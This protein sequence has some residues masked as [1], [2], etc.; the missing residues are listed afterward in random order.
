[1][2]YRFKID[3]IPKDE[4]VQQ[5][6]KDKMI[7]KGEVIEV[8]GYSEPAEA[9]VCYYMGGI[10]VN[11]PLQAFLLV[12]EECYEPT[13]IH[14]CVK[15]KH[16]KKCKKIFGRGLINSG[17]YTCARYEENTITE[18]EIKKLLDESL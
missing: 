2:K 11:I 7:R 15:C 17:F 18:E 4:E 12:A 13:P 1:M 6:L 9:V 14:L 8:V 16:Y 10:Q 3:Y 5:L